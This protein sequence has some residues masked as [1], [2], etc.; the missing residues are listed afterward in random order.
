M[1]RTGMIGGRRGGIDGWE[2]GEDTNGVAVC[3]GRS[4]SHH[5]WVLSLY[6]Y[7]M[8]YYRLAGSNR[9]DWKFQQMVGVLC[10]LLQFLIMTGRASED[11]Q[12]KTKRQPRRSDPGAKL[13]G[14]FLRNDTSLLRSC[15]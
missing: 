10:Y 2:R 11:R 1:G 13:I 4:F 9:H 3:W 7:L 8:Y 5:Y 15:K 14:S 6:P 12:D